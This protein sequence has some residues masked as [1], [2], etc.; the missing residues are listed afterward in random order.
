MKFLW[1]WKKVDSFLSLQ[2]KV[3]I[4]DEMYNGTQQYF[5]NSRSYAFQKQYK[6]TD[7]S[8]LFVATAPM[9][10]SMVFKYIFFLENKT[11]TSPSNKH[12]START[13]FDKILPSKFSFC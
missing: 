6:I 3:R 12:Q 7:L 11:L 2:L 1:Q 9:Q 5:L 4:F 10:T 13:S 8:Y